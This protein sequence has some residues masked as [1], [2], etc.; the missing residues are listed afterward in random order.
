MDPSSKS[1]AELLEL[2]PQI[3]KEMATEFVRVGGR[4]MDADPNS[5][6]TACFLLAT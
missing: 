3:L 5:Q 1:V 6:E 4:F 2:V